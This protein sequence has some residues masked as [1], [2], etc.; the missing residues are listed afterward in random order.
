[1]NVSIAVLTYNRRKFLRRC[2]NSLLNQS[3][4]NSDILVIDNG[5]TDGTLELLKNYPVRIIVDHTKKLSYLFNLAWKNTTGDYIAYLADDVE[6][7]PNW[8]ENALKTF[9]K[10]REIGAVGG[11]I[12]STRKQEMRLLHEE[13]KRSK[14][15]SFFAYIYDKIIMEGKK[16]QPGILAKSGAYSMGASLESSLKIRSS[17]PV[18]LL[19]TSAMVIN[20][21]VFLKIGGFDENFHFNHADGDL[22]IRMGRAGYKLMFNPRVIASHH[23]RPSL[24]RDP[25]Y[26][27]RDTGYF[28]AKDIRPETLNGWLSFILNIFYFNAYWMYKFLKT[29]DSK[30]L[31]GIRA[32]VT[33]VIEYLKG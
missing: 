3:Y 5:S 26:I 19:T 9:E 24:S 12:I 18:D 17:I 2:L 11:P 6:L 10:S 4:K 25:Y 20:R 22:F 30:Q 29:G 7:H 8:L 23:V 28:F 32:F 33:G 16:F 15:L 31:K 21:E 13:A 1:M 14:F 27:A